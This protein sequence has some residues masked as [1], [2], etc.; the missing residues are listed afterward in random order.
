MSAPRVPVPS[1]ALVPG[2]AAAAGRPL[3]PAGARPHGRRVEVFVETA[4][5]SYVKRDW[6]GGR[7]RVR[8]A[9]PVPCPFDYG[10]VVGL[11]AADGDAQDAIWFGPPARPCDVVPGLVAAVAR[12]DD[13][14]VCDDKW[15]VTPDGVLS[16]A[17]EA[18]VPRFFAVYVWVKRLA[19]RRC[20]FHGIERS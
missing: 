13:G 19:L 6:D 5:G 14:G 3:P 11:V 12:F 1:P 8:F 20:S 7:L 4:R 16:P 18:R 2:A 9:S 17:D 15:I 10:H